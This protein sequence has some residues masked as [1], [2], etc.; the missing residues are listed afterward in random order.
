MY[1]QPPRT[2]ALYHLLSRGL[3]MY[4]LYNYS[5]AGGTYNTCP[6]HYV[7]VVLDARPY[8]FST[9]CTCSLLGSSSI[10]RP[11]YR[12][13]T[14]YMYMYIQST[15]HLCG[16]FK[17]YMPTQEPGICKT[18]YSISPPYPSNQSPSPP[19]TNPFSSN[20]ELEAQSDARYYLS[21]S[22][23]TFPTSPF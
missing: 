7:L 15:Y 16:H 10:T 6:V 4:V 3:I 17:R 14:E 23:C 8:T 9:Y 5:T 18:W 20:P 12:V 2:G 21:S 1:G 11:L 13:V 19:A 22:S